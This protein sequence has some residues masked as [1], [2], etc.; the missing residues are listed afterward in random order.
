MEQPLPNRRPFL[1]GVRAGVPVILGYLPV[2]LAYAVIARQA[3]FTVLETVLMSATVFG[4]ASQMM[5]AGMYA[6]GA[7]IVAMILATFILNLR[8]FIMSTCVFNRLER[9]KAGLR[10][11]A[12]FGITDETFAVFTTQ[13]E[14]CRSAPFLFGLI[15]AAYLAW[16]GGSALGALVSGFLPA[17]LSASLGVSLY[18]MFIGLLMPSVQS[19]RRLALLVVLSALVNYVLTLFLPASWSLILSTLAGAAAGVCFVDPAKKEAESHD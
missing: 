17:L 19:N 15:A 11:I 6:Q 18:A 1:A 13:R 5:A 14:D 3:G 16:V 7:S 12:A 9:T 8:H 4:G 2:G 10:L